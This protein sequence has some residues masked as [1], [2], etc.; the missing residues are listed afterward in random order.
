MVYAPMAIDDCIAGIADVDDRDVQ[1]FWARSQAKDELLASIL[2]EPLVGAPPPHRPNALSLRRPL[3]I[4]LASFLA[5]AAVIVGATSVD[6]FSRH[7]SP[8]TAKLPAGDRSVAVEGSWDGR[9]VEQYSAS[10]LT[11][12]AF[13]FDGTVTS[14][15]GIGDGLYVPVTFE[16]HEW[17]RGGQTPQVTVSMMAPLPTSVGNAG[18]EPG[19]RLLVSGEPRRGGEPLNAPVAWP[20]GFT[21][22]YAVDTADGWRE[23]LK[24]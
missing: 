8:T 18:Y 6:V 17:F 23:I 20:C 4:A 2:K 1:A 12:R 21:R 24:G 15:R 13:A 10:T 19:T 11:N 14:I 9:C 5:S 7:G 3:R 16:V 22:S